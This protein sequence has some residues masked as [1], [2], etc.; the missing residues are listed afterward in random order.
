MIAMEPMSWDGRLLLARLGVTR[1]Q[2]PQLLEEFIAW[3]LGPFGPH[4]DAGSLLRWS[5]K[6]VDP[7][8]DAT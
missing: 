4:E 7:S 1:Q 3:G 5:M 2:A 8:L 6:P